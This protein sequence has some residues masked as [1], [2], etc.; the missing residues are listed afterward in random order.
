M[1]FFDL[2][3]HRVVPGQD[4]AGA[5]NVCHTTIPGHEHDASW[6]RSVSGGKQWTMNTMCTH[7][8][9]TGISFTPIQEKETDCVKTNT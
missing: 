6:P 9:L 7:S 3:R 4:R 5:A 8:V 2:V 1:A